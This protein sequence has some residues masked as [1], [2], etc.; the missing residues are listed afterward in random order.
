MLVSSKLGVM[1]Q[2]SPRF[3]Q[4]TPPAGGQAPFQSKRIPDSFVEALKTNTDTSPWQQQLEQERRAKLEQQRSF[5]IRRRQEHLIFSQKELARQQQITA[6][7]D[8]LQQLLTEVKGLGQEIEVAVDQ[9]I[10]A[11]GVYHVN[12][13]EKLRQLIKLMRQKIHDSATWLAAFNHRA[14]G[15]MGYWGQ[16]QTS[17]TKFMLSH[18]RYMVTQTG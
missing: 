8:Q 14:R 7:Q 9:Q 6:L 12:F 3:S 13:F 16:V 11:P 10:V 18:E 1:N 17:G 5:E 15:K 2:I 4:K